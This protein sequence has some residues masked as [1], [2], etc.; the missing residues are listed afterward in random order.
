MFQTFSTNFCA[1]NRILLGCIDSQKTSNQI[2]KENDQNRLYNAYAP[3]CVP[4][5]AQTHS[6]DGFECIKKSLEHT[7]VL[8]HDTGVPIGI[9]SQLGRQKLG[10]CTKT[11]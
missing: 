10:L 11:T 7:D 2:Q 5:V 8:T 4:F 1:I 6:R 3:L 9:L